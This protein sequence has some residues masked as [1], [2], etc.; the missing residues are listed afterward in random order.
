MN[1][2]NHGEF[3]GLGIEVTM[4]NGLVKIISPIDDSPAEKAGIRAG[5]VILAVDG[6]PLTSISLT[7][8][9][10]KMRGKKG[11]SIILTVINKNQNKPKVIAIK[12]GIIPLESVKSRMLTSVYGYLR[13]SQFQE[14]TAKKTKKALNNLKKEAKGNLRGII[15]DLRNNPGGLLESAVDVSNL[16]LDSQKLGKNKLITFTQGRIKAND[17]TFNA[18]SSDQLNGLPIIILINNGSASA[19]E[20]VAGALQDHKRANCRTTK[21]RQGSIQTL[22]PLDEKTAIKLTIAL[23][24][25]P[26]GRVIQTIGIKPD[27]EIDNLKLKD[28]QSDAPFL[29]NITEE[30]LE[31]HIE[32]QNKEAKQKR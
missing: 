21:F 24:Y 29:L 1:E 22:L 2:A 27:I 7:N 11:T 18:T 6:K 3:S 9:I 10:K 8:A 13:I 23:Y 4:E 15:L 14:D 32:I 31:Q 5:D 20:I 26:H 12:R 17:E 28:H 25:T 30:S 19:A 16:F